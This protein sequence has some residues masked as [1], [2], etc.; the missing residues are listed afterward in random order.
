M[1]DIEGEF[2]VDG[3]MACRAFLYGAVNVYDQIAT[4]GVFF[5]RNRVVA[6]ANDV[7]WAVLPEILAVGLE[8]AV[9]VD[10]NDAD[11]APSVGHRCEFEFVSKP[12]SQIL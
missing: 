9:I 8:H 10:Q 5:T 2:V 12:I 11:F 6:E 7:G 1:G 4:P 3:S